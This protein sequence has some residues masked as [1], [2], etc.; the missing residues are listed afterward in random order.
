MDPQGRPILHVRR[1]FSLIKSRIYISKVDPETG[2]EE[3]IGESEMDWHVWRRRYNLFVGQR[4]FA[5]IDSGLL[6]WDFTLADEKGEKL[7]ELNRNFAGFAREIFTDTGQYALRLDAAPGIERNL[8]YDERAV[9]LATAMT[10]DVDYFSR[11]SGGGVHM[12]F[13]PFFGGFGGGGEAEAPA[14]GPATG[15]VTKRY[16]WCS[17]CS[18]CYWIATYSR[19]LWESNTRQL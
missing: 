11:H 7:A 14:P 13:F 6:A 9:A 19:C 4:Q 3:L 1:P 2:K 18:G 10:I 16:C 5:R 17:G 15:D 8:T 12:P